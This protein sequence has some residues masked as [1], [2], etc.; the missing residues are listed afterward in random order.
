[1]IL[2]PVSCFNNYDYTDLITISLILII[3]NRALRKDI[4]IAK[5]RWSSQAGPGRE[6][7]PE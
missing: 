7:H 4:E 6:S 2:I 3:Y 5:D 1:M